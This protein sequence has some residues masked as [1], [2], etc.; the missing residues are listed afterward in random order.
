MGKNVTRLFEQFQPESYELL[1]HPDKESMTFTGTVTIV[2][3]KVGRPSKR[4]TFHQKELRITSAKVVKHDKKGATDVAVSRINNQDSFDEVR[5]HADEMIYPGKYT[6]TLEFNG[7]IN[8]QM[9]GLYPCFFTHE[10]QEKQLIATQF[11]SHHAREAFPCIDEPEA[12][13]TFDL[14][15]ISPV[16]ETVLANTPVKKQSTKGSLLTTTF[17]TSPKMSSYLLAFVI[18]ELHSVSAKAKDGTIVSSWA[19]VAQPK[20]HLEYANTEA[21]RCLEF[22]NDYFETPFPL[23][24]VDQVALPDFDSLA[25]ENWGLI[26]FREVGLLSD[27]VNRSISGEQ[28]ITLV[29]AHELSH[30]WFGNLV[31]MRWWD[32]LWLNESFASIMENIAPDRLHP[33]WQQWEE[34]ATTRALSASNRDLYKDVQSVSVEVKHPD[35]ISTLFDPAIVYAKGARLLNMLYDYVGEDDFRAGLKNYFAEHA[36][37]NTSRDDLWKEFSKVSKRDIGHLMTPWLTQSGMPLLSVNRD[38]DRLKLSQQRFLLDGEDKES[39]WPIPLLADTSLETN[40]LESRDASI[41]LS[42]AQPTPIFNA[43]GTGHYVVY[44]DSL[45]DRKKLAQQVADRSLSTLTRINVLNDMLLLS[46]GG[47]QSLTEILELVEQ[48]NEEPRDAVWSLLARSIG[49]A[50]N[51]VDSDKAAEKQLKALKQTISKYWYNKL[52]WDDKPEDDPNTQHLR[53]TALALSIAGENPAAIAKALELFEKAGSV[54]ALP[55][56]RRSL[57]GGA[58]VRH[59]KPEA[60]EQMMAEYTASQN[61]EVRENIC[62]ILCHIRDPKVAK[63]IIDWAL[64]PETGVVRQQDI[65]HW[66][67]YLMRN[68]HTRELAWD[69]LI[70]HWDYLL[71]LFGGGKHM[72]Y[73]IWYAAGPLSTKQWQE[74]FT[75]FFTPKLTDPASARNIKISFGEIAARINWRDREEPEIKKYLKKWS[76]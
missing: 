1:L 10:G 34:F 61:S 68:Y 11:E 35:E 26:T 15:L 18:G 38:G 62:A 20:S 30:Q 17:E 6:V 40:M 57:I 48:C 67:A 28:L 37:G 41:L 75:E 59:G 14:T 65:A 42:A 31:T 39:L 5:L 16:G 50:Q 55:A 63:R 56:E 7:T 12:K 36:Y 13:A 49:Q 24:K 23:P 4:L 69:W 76:A 73:F 27:P 54:E 2:G 32:D 43:H 66:F 33:D 44:Y 45:D 22:F 60:I 53:T 9:N 29:I 46:R 64:T 8:R 70:T 25:M 52:G 19:T 71:E 21:I 74:K 72:E 51:F 47:K 3:K 58:V